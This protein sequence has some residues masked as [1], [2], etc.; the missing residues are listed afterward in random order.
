MRYIYIILGALFITMSCTNDLDQVPPNLANADSLTD[1]DGVLNAAYFYQL[2]TVTP[3]AVMGDFRADNAFMFE[4][5]F[6]EFDQYDSG[7]TQMDEQFF[8]PFYTAC[9][10]AI[11]SCNI[12][13]ENSESAVEIGEA[14]FLRALTYFKLVR[15]FGDA[16]I[17]LSDSPSVTDQSILARQ[18]VA[19]VYDEVIIPDLQDAIEV[20]P[21]TSSNGRATK[22]AAQGILG[23]VYV[24]RGDFSN[25]ERE[26]AAVVNDGGSS[27]IALQENFSEIFGV[28]FDLNPEIIFATQISSSIVDEYGFSEFWSW[29]GGLDTK[30]LMPLDTDLIDAFD[31]SPGDLRREVSINDTLFA[32]PKF[33]Q[34]DG[35]DHDWIELRLADVILLYAEALNENGNTTAALTELNKIRNRAGLADSSASSQGDVRT[36]IQDERRLE[37]AFEGQRWFD[38]VRTGTVDQEMGQT[39]DPNYHLFPLPDS[40]RLSS[41]GVI[42][43]NPGY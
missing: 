41:F 13:V 26:L 9:Y 31:A 1:F 8:S 19:A 11:L 43:Q 14:K 42:T 27:G 33:P 39:I 5:P 7:L 35:A 18:P 38:L 25:A 10:R 29:S 30:S 6:D 21:N 28:T 24:Q 22:Y 3:M 34:T 4:A 20:L 17:N 36:A 12:V 2:G 16:T 15:V 32:S 23:K 37:F 40:E